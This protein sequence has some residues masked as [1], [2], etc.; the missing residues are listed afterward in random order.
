[1]KIERHQQTRP[2]AD[3]NPGGTFDEGGDFFMRLSDHQIVPAGKIAVVDLE[4]GRIQLW[5]PDDF[6]SIIS[7][8][9]VPNGELD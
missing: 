2:L 3:V 5:N 7:L 9:G 6:V 1:M 4:D 8:K